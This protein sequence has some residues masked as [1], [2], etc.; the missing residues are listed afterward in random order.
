MTRK[1][2]KKEEKDKLAQYIFEEKKQ[3]NIP[4]KELVSAEIELF[5]GEKMYMDDTYIEPKIQWVGV[6][7]GTSYTITNKEW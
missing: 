7:E 2:G 3:L 1:S 6:A 4:R 5:N